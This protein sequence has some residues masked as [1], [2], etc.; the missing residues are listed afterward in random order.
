MRHDAASATKCRKEPRSGAIS[1]SGSYPAL[2]VVQLMRQNVALAV[3]GTEACWGCPD[4]TKSQWLQ[5]F[6]AKRSLLAKV[7]NV[8]ALGRGVLPGEQRDDP[9]ACQSEVDRPRECGLAFVER[10]RCFRPLA[11]ERQDQP[12]RRLSAAALRLSLRQRLWHSVGGR[13][14]RR[15]PC[16]SRESAPP[17]GRAL[18]LHRALCDGSRWFSSAWGIV[19]IDSHD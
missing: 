4:V 13:D 11:A 2:R 1:G 18:R 19:R 17:A 15:R 12:G 9:T 14:A 3:G 8:L 6:T 16:R 5:G 7:G 10:R